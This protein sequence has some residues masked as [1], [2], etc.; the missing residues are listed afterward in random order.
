MICKSKMILLLLI[1]ALTLENQSSN[2]YPKI[3][4]NIDMPAGVRK[5]PFDYNS[6]NVKQLSHVIPFYR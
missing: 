2:I 5:L 3:I 1:Y 4:N 6:N